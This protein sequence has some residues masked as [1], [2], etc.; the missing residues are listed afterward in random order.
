[1]VRADVLRVMRDYAWARSRGWD[2]WS[3]VPCETVIS[4]RQSPNL[5]CT[6][7]SKWSTPTLE[8][9]NTFPLDWV[10]AGGCGFS[11]EL[12]W[13]AKRSAGDD[14]RRRGMVAVTVANP[15]CDPTRGDGDARLLTASK[16]CTN[17][18]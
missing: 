16:R 11:A 12:R 15:R 10:L 1:V 18:V 13:W 9:M 3:L 2:R 14:L 6:C 8:D 17:A 5:C 7:D 4:L